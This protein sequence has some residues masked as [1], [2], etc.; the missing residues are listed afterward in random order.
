MEKALLQENSI[1]ETCSVCGNKLTRYGSK[2]LKDGMLCRNCAKLCSR[3]LEKADYAERTVEQ[4]K[5]HLDYRRKNQELVGEFKGNK[6]IEGKY[7]LFIDDDNKT[8]LITKRS[9]FVK[10]NADV[11]NI[12]EIGKID[13]VERK[14]VRS[15]GSDF[16]VQLYVNHPQFTTLKFQVNEFGCLNKDSEEYQQALKL[17]YEYVNALKDRK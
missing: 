1:Q 5:E 10:D 14:Y 11:F 17:A 3:W 16:Y 6:V 12:A 15:D 7:N 4:I 13:I 2:Q 9:D 8:F